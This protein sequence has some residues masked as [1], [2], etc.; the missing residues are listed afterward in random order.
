M[1]DNIFLMLFIVCSLWC[2]VALLNHSNRVSPEEYE[3][4]IF[5]SEEHHI[6]I[7]VYLED[8]FLSRSEYIEILENING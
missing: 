8:G 7:D 6:N 3:H 4:V 1:R 5:L 2:I